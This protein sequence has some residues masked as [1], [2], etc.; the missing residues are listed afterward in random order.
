[1]LNLPIVQDCNQC[2][3]CCR[4]GGLCALRGPSWNRDNPIP[5]QFDGVCELLS[6]ESKCRIIEKVI[7]QGNTYSLRQLGIVGKC[8]FPDLRLDNPPPVC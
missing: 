6:P 1:M 7:Q 5:L 4:I 2:G 3:Q 8:D